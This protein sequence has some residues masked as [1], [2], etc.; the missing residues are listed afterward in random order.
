MKKIFTTIA[1]FG[2]LAAGCND[3]DNM[4]ETT[5][6][7]PP[8]S[9]EEASDY[10][11]ISL[12]AAGGS[13]T[14]AGYETGSSTENEVTHIRFYFFDKDK[15]AAKV[16]KNPDKGADAYDSYFD[17]TPMLGNET[18]A[19]N[20]GLTVEKTITVSLM[21]NSPEG[22]PKPQYVV[23][24]LNPTTPALNGD[25]NPDLVDLEK[26]A[27]NF[28]PVVNKPF[29]MSNSVYVDKENPTDNDPT[30][31]NYTKIKDLYKSMEEAQKDENKTIIYVERAMAR[32][33]L[34][35]GQTEDS[36]ITPAGDDYTPTDGD[37]TNVFDTGETYKLYNAPA[38]TAE[39]KVFVKFLGWTVTSTPIKA[40]LL[41][42]I[43][44]QWKNDLFEKNGNEP[45]NVPGYHRSF[46]G[47]NPTLK[48]ANND[49]RLSAEY[50]FFSY[51][52]IA[53]ED[54]DAHHDFGTGATAA[55]MYIQENAAENGK[56]AVLESHASK[57]IVA[58]QLVDET[59]KGM[60]IVEYGFKYYE[61]DA[62]LQ[63]FADQLALHF[64][65][66]DNTTKLAKADLCYKTQFQ[67]KK[68]AGVDIEGGYFT[69][70]ALSE[71]GAAKTWYLDESTT[72]S[73]ETAVNK[74]IQDMVDSRLLYWESGH[75]YYYFPIRHL[76]YDA[77]KEE[78]PAPGHYGVVRNH[79]YKADIS[80]LVGLGT[81]VFDPDETIYPE[82]PSRD[83]HILAA[84]IRILQ[85]RVVSQDYEFSW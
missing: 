34:T 21:L 52:D 33:D 14:R 43:N 35:I 12:V 30:I 32:I 16:R 15:K 37:K 51:N 72:A 3:T 20:A 1:L 41:K 67:Y 7:N 49:T 10:L 75:T 85:W 65:D 11:A 58:A 74:Y 54:G 46:W 71:T 76:G 6:D 84:E 42:A 28:V 47:I 5:P 56:N 18:G 83:G 59:G 31:L 36:K 13:G 73:D 69:Y 68:E 77:D 82:K 24:I 78:S 29:L 19:G 79:I 4:P 40:N 62:L 8:A 39:K 66:K 53:N 55:K 60:D 81:P 23:A 80:N 9:T 57:V 48:K 22:A 17:Y 25:N 63:Y 26:I 70:V 64:H 44:L 50:A 38:G 45:W 2:L 27:A 61:A